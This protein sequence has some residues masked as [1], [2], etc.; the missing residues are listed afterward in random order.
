MP[1]LGVIGLS[2][3]LPGDAVPLV[4]GPSGIVLAPA[5]AEQLQDAFVRAFDAH[6][7]LGGSLAE[8]M[9]AVRT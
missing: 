5:V 4:Q 7:K 3:P 8:L 6:P 9:R 1:L 2:A